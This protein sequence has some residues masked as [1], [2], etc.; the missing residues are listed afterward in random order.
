MKVKRCEVD[1]MAG[2]AQQQV[3][4]ARPVFLLDLNQGL[5]LS[6]VVRVNRA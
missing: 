2:A 3:L 5:E 4:F 1:G 6:Q